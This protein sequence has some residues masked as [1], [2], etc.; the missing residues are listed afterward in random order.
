MHSLSELFYEKFKRY[1]TLTAIKCRERK[2]SYSDLSAK[3]MSIASLLV[4]RG[5]RSEAVGILGQRSLDSYFGILGTIYAGCY[6]VP[7]NSKYTSERII[8]IIKSAN[9]KYLIGDKKE[10]E[11]I[12]N[13]LKSINFS[14]VS[15]IIVPEGDN[16][17][18]QQWVGRKQLINIEAS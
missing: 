7:I 11:T 18:D 2:V 13:I 15:L 10:I 12:I 16:L 5:A 3:A 14:P 17:N 9:I 4:E 1:G 8:S 6:W